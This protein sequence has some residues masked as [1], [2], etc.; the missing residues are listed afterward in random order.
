D[1]EAVAIRD[2]SGELATIGLWG[3]LARDV[4]VAAGARADEIADDAIPMRRAGSVPV[5]PAP[6]HAARISY[7]GEHGWELTTT[8]EW[9]VTV[10]DR[11][12]AA[13]AEPVGYR[14]LDALRMEKGYRYYG[15]D[16]T[17]LDT[18]FE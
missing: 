12:I 4:V 17:M 11:V 3:P 14:A 18:P 1:D 6:V 9:A 7:A 13:G 2:V 8:V 16:L 15:T 5:G 10:W